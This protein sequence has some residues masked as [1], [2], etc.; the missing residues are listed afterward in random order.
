MLIL[1]ID[2]VFKGFTEF[3]YPKADPIKHTEGVL[4]YCG[5]Y[6]GISAHT[7]PIN[8]CRYSKP[9]ESLTHLVCEFRLATPT[10]L[11]LFLRFLR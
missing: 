5:Q 2:T 11:L 6:L 10:W 1:Y 4:R 7:S 8:H 9:K 3:S